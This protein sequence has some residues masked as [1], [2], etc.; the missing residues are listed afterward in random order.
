MSR[1]RQV[2]WAGVALG[3]IAAYITVPPI[4]IRTR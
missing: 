2:G 4:T 1:A 3:V